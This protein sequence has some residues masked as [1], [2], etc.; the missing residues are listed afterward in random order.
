M[1]FFFSI[2]WGAAKFLTKNTHFAIFAFNLV[3]AENRAKMPFF[4]SSK[5]IVD[6]Q[7]LE[8]NERDYSRNNK[9]INDCSEKWKLI[10]FERLN[11]TKQKV[12]LIIIL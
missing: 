6:P 2:I 5:K 7:N 4:G 1:T 8:I 9:N 11:W 12:R 3:L 10:D